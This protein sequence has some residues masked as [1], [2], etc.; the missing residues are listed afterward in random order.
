MIAETVTLMT[1][2]Q[3]TPTDAE[4]VPEST[5]CYFCGDSKPL[6]VVDKKPACGRCLDSRP[7]L[8]GANLDEVG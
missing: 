8:R 3:T 4:P 6:A 1:R 2:I 7:E 5:R